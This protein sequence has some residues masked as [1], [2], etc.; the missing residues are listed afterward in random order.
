MFKTFFA[1]LGAA[2]AM[3]AIALAFGPMSPIPAPIFW[4][5]LLVAFLWSAWPLLRN[6]RG[7]VLAFLALGFLAASLSACAGIGNLMP[8]SATNPALQQILTHV[9]TC[10]RTYQG[11][12]GVPPTFT[13]QITCKAQTPGAAAAPAPAEPPK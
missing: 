4:G 3:L 9:E 11:G 7:R 10:D 13:F 2:F 6:I 12:T 8:A 5:L 1:V